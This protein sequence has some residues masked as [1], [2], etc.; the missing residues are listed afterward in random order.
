MRFAAIAAV[1]P[2]GLAALVVERSY[3]SGPRRGRPCLSSSHWEI[4]GMWPI[5]QF[6]LGIETK[7]PAPDEPRAPATAGGLDLVDIAALIC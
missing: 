6:A 2:V 7:I 5:V 3:P 1:D 4:P